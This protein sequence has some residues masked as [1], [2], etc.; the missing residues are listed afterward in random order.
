MSCLICERKIEFYFSKTFNCYNLEKVDYWRCTHCG[1]VLSRTHMELSPEKWGQLNIEYHSSYQDSDSNPDDP[2]WLAR[3]AKQAAMLECAAQI[4]L[5]N[6]GHW[7][8]YACGD[9]KLSDLLQERGL[10]LLKYEH[11]M[12]ARTDYLKNSDLADKRFNFVL[13]TSV[14]EHL[15]RREHFD[16]IDNL[17]TSQG[18]VMGLHTLV[19]EEIPSDPS[20]FYLLPVH[21]SFHTNRS[22]QLLFHQWGYTCSVYHLESRLWLWFKEDAET[23][24]LRLKE[25]GHAGDAFIFKEDFVDYWK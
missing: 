12:P 16:A 23:I 6:R 10:T 17:V 18:G 21:C 20:W 19:R 15:T 13:T 11:Y 25:A 14:F 24:R 2:K 9:G 1:F 22:M 7:L 5:I 8:D 3:I 4:G